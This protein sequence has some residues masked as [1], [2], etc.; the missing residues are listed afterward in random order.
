MAPA[1]NVGAA[2]PVGIS[3]A[4]AS[5][6][7]MNDAAEYIV[8]I[9]ERHGR[10]AEWAESAVRD[11]ESV[12][13]EQALELGVIDL[14]APDVPTLLADVDGMPR[15]ELGTAGEFFDHVERENS[16]DPPTK[17][18]NRAAINPTINGSVDA[19]EKLRFTGRKQSRHHLTPSTLSDTPWGR[20]D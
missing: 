14:I 4:V 5:E 8:S 11:A 12:S 19:A 2:Q 3:G 17:S 13:A 18:A 15:I 20:K 6:K 16:I 9:A 10:N 7:A 1:T